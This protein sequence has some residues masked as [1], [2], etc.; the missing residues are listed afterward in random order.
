[1]NETKRG[2]TLIE[3]MVVI[4]IVGILAA[5]AYPSYT[6]F[7]KRSSRAEAKA[8]LLEN[9]QFLERNFTVANRYDKDSG[10]STISST[11]LPVQKTPR[12]GTAARYTID[13]TSTASTFSLKAKRVEDG[14]MADDACGT[15]TLDN[16]GGKDLEDGTASVATCWHK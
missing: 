14:P 15:F 8:A 5:I 6:E 11:S 4:S 12:D 1:M 3:L 16:L 7:V 13:V 10:G 2:F 9:A